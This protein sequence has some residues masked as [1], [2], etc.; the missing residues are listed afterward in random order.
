MTPSPPPRRLRLFVAVYPPPEIAAALLAALE[1]LDDLPALRPVE[2]DQVH[3][4]LHFVGDR[5]PSE[6]EAIA[7]T[8]RRAAGGLEPFALTPQRL[9]TLPRRPP[10]R[11]VAAET[12]RPAGLLELQR[13]LV[14]RLARNPRQRTGD[15]FRPHLTLC[16]FKSPARLRAIGRP[17]AVPSFNVSAI[18]LVRSTLRPEGA[19]HRTVLAIS[20]G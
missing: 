2:R 6:L 11:L 10:A 15:R 7:E 4:T 16:R 12:D 3:M 9:I 8:V 17:I 13:R 1:D 14:T 18:A 19:Q 5:P 20:L